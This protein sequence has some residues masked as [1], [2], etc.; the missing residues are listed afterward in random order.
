MTST[1]QHAS[2]VELLLIED[3]PA[4]V[5][6]MREGLKALSVES[7]LS[8]VD[9]GIDA[10]S[11]LRREGDFQDAPRPQLILLDLKLPGSPGYEV[12]REIKTSSDLRNIPVVIL[13]S[14]KTRESILKAYSLSANCYIAKPVNLDDYIAI[15]KSIESFW[16]DTVELPPH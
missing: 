4:D 1:S 6:F 8:V 13:S 5:L 2:A 15:V 14:A 7:N 11:F 12:L 3:N 9:N 10:L 16:L